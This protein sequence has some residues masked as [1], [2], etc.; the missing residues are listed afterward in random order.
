[1]ARTFD[2]TTEIIEKTS[3]TISIGSAGTLSF[4]VKPAWSSGDGVDHY[5]FRAHTSGNRFLSFQKFS[6]NNIYCGWLQVSALDDDRI[7]VADTGLFTSGTLAHWAFRWN[8]TA[9]T[10]EL[11]KNGVSVA[12]RTSALVTYALTSQII[13]G[14]YESTGSD[15]RGD[16]SEFGLWTESLGNEDIA[17]LAKGFSPLLVRPD[18]LLSYLPLVGKQSPEIDIVSN[19]DFTVTGATAGDHPGI[20]YPTQAFYPTVAGSPPPPATSV[21]TNTIWF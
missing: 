10:C 16:M 11:F 3:P 14:N 7:V 9:N 8:D 13:I 17:V 19:D 6:D 21:P 1:M 20:F 5:F 4:W 12:S 18:I 2:A 15:A